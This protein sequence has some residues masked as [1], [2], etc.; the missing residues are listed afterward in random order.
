MQLKIKRGKTL[1]L[2]P[3]NGEFTQKE[4][5]PYTAVMKKQG[6]SVLNHGERVN[7]PLETFDK[8]GILAAFK[9]AAQQ[10]VHPTRR[11]VAQKVS[12]KSKGSVKPA[13]G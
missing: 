4:L 13:R 10:G 8:K 2:L 3:I 6:I 5:Q 12:S 1:W 7:V 9:Q 11:S